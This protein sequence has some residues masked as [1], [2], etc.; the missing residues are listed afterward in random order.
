ML[1][2]SFLVMH[3]KD[4]QPVMQPILT[5]MISSLEF[6]KGIDDLVF[7]E[8]GFPVP[9]PVRQADPLDLIPDIPDPEHW[10]AFQTE[11]PIGG[12][13]AFYLRELPQLG[14]QLTRYVPYPNPGDYPF[15]RIIMEKG[16]TAYSL[17]LLPDRD[18]TTRGNILLKKG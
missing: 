12:L 3:W 4:N 7:T 15:A 13:Q 9:E 1:V 16:G 17:G 5:Q 14:W 11:L 10:K 18:Q 6:I 2:L 8:G